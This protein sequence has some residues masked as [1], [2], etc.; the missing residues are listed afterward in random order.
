MEDFESLPPLDVNDVNLEAMPGAN[1]SNIS[2]GSN[3]NGTDA[4]AAAPIPVLIDKNIT[5]D[6]IFGGDSDLDENENDLAF[7]SDDEINVPAPTP[8]PKFKKKEGAESVTSTS[9]SRTSKKKASK[10]GE[11]AGEGDNEIGNDEPLDPEAAA[12]KQVANDFEEALSRLKTKRPKKIDGD[13]PEIDEMIVNLV[14]KMREAASADHE[15]NRLQQPAIAKIKLLP[16]VSVQL[17]KTHL[18]DQ[19][20]DNNILDGMKL[21]CSSSIIYF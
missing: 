1:N 11:K 8:L 4:T 7:S 14:E 15:F 19:F 20:L 3:S 16:K 10:R 5:L 21:W 9:V 6:D 13:D 17:S 12:K 2:D 18:Y